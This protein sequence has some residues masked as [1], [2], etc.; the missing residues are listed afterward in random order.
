MIVDSSSAVVNGTVGQ[1]IQFDCFITGKPTPTVDWLPVSKLADDHVV[2]LGNGSLVI[3]PLALEHAG[4][5]ICALKEG[6][7]REFRLNVSPMA[8]SEDKDKF[9][10][11]G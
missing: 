2:N 6:D 11:G 7:V 8:D 5:Y 3:N 9:T 1:R 10:I 4:M